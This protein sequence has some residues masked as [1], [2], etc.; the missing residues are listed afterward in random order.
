MAQTDTPEEA[1]PVAK[2]TLGFLL[3]LGLVRTVLLA[4]TGSLTALGFQ[5]AGSARPWT[6]ASST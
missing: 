1:L 2:L 5:V 3:A 4:A 6:L